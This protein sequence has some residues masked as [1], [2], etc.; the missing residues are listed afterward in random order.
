MR[1][2]D[3]RRTRGLWRFGEHVGPTTFGI[4]HRDLNVVIEPSQFV[5]EELPNP[6]LVPG[7]GLNINQLRVKETTSMRIEHTVEAHADANS[8]FECVLS[9]LLATSH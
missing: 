9:V 2:E 8:G 6:G 1:G 7:N 5:G 3:Y 4:S